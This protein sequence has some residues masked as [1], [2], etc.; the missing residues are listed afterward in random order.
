MLQTLIWEHLHAP[1]RAQ[2]KGLCL[3]PLYFF[4]SLYILPVCTWIKCLEEIEK[5]KQNGKSIQSRYELLNICESALVII[6]YSIQTVSS[7]HCSLFLVACWASPCAEFMLARTSITALYLLTLD[8]LCF[9]FLRGAILTKC[10]ERSLLWRSSL[11]TLIE[12]WRFWFW[13]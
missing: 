1:K 5:V 2:I 6:A 8:C 4:L 7:L 9:L 10:L 12:T 11:K 13:F 3:T